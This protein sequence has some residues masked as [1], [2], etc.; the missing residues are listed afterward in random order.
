[1]VTTRCTQEN[2]WRLIILSTYRDWRQ[3]E[4]ISQRSRPV[5]L[6]M[7]VRVALPPPV[8]HRTRVNGEILLHC[9]IG[10]LF[11]LEGQGN[12]VSRLRITPIAH[13]VPLVILSFNLLTKSP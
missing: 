12:L 1:M 4:G 9:K 5:F 7:A 11:Y 10:R 3:G 2:L 6:R 8:I 13:I